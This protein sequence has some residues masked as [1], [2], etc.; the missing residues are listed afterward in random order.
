MPESPAISHRQAP[1]LAGRGL[2]RHLRPALSFAGF[3]ALIWLLWPAFE[4]AVLD[5]WWTGIF[6]GGAD[7]LSGALA[8][9]DASGACW[10]FIAE[11]F[12]QLMY[13][14]YPAAERWRVD[15][16]LLIGAAL[17]VPIMVPRIPRKGLWIG[18]FVTAYPLLCVLLFFGSVGGLARVDTG[19]WGGLFLTLVI[20]VFAFAFA[21]PAGIGLALGRESRLPV[22]RMLCGTWVE[23]WRSVPTLVVLF[24]AVI[25]L[26]LFLPADINIDKLLRALIALSILMSCHIAEAVRGALRALPAG[27]RDAA[28]ALGLHRWQANVYVILPQALTLST[29]QITNIVIGMFKETSLLVIIGLFDLLGM[30]QAISGDPEW[31]GS[32]ARA[33]G[34]LFVGLIYWAFC[35]GMSRYSAFLERRTRLGTAR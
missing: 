24:V 10:P 19:A 29:P 21:L 4:W 33:T 14:A 3:I 34:Y 5:A 13:G 26:P 22:L 16:G 25:M 2:A 28:R 7:A 9:P 31:H 17:L 20:G 23:L 30:V 12:G 1:T 18:L 6:N 11:R 35:F 15:L 8:C 32:A 27:Q